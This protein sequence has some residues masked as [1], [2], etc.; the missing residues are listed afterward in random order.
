MQRC[1]FIDLSE[2]ARMTLKKTLV[3]C[4]LALTLTAPLI[5]PKPADAWGWR[6]GWHAGWHHG[7]GWRGGVYVGGPAIVVRAP[8]YYGYA[9]GYYAP[10]YHWI[11]PHYTPYGALIPG[12]WGY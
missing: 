3:T 7:W 4:A 8:G 1:R 10:A 9:P 5:T 2:E 6:G 11:G 12:H